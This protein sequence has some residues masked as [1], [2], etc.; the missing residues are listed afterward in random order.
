MSEATEQ[1]VLPELIIGETY[2][3]LWRF[4][5]EGET[6]E[7]KA[8]AKTE[9]VD[10]FRVG[11][12]TILVFERL[13]RKREDGSTIFYYFDNEDCKKQVLVSSDIQT[14]QIV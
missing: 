6:E 11:D 7:V 3:V 4:I 14:Y 9:W 10:S 5:P 2:T 12:E 13:D 8:Y 1:S